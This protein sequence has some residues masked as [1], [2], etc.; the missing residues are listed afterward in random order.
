M[1]QLSYGLG[2]G[3]KAAGPVTLI[4]V[5]LRLKKDMTMRIILSRKGLDSGNSRMPS[6]VYDL[7]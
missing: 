4:A 6:P 2:R 1:F 3:G 5:E 7:I